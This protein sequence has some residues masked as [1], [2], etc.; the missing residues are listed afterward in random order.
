MTITEIE[1][2]VIK[3]EMLRMLKM[4]YFPILHF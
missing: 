2:S 1:K 3:H 4:L